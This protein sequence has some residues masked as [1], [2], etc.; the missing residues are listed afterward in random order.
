METAAPLIAY[1][2]ALSVAAAIPGPGVV[3]LIGYS[4]SGSL[5]PALF[6]LLGMAIGDLV[7]LSLAVAGLAAIIALFEEVLLAVKVLGGLYLLYLGWKF[8]TSRSGMTAISGPRAQSAPRALAGG[9]AMTLGNPKVV[10][11]YLALLPAVLD[12]GSVDLAQWTMMAGLTLLT[13][14]AV[15]T[16]YALLGYRAR[17]LLGRSR[18]VTRANRIA[19]GIIGAAGAVILAQTATALVRRA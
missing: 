6:F 7:F 2:A 14:F 15:L 10:V 19:A 5:R 9:L 16:P 1:V 11:F 18:L 3:A 4:L 13:L 12:L 8:W 17:G